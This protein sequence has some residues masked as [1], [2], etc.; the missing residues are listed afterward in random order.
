VVILITAL[1]VDG[2][3]NLNNPWMGGIRDSGAAT[4]D[5]LRGAVSTTTDTSSLGSNIKD[6]TGLKEIVGW[7][8][9][10][11]LFLHV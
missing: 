3:F 9:C 6:P 1:L 4:E 5:W 11:K 7:I 2:C 8:N 10:L